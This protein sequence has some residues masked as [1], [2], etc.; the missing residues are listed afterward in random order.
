M[1]PNYFI[2]PVLELEATDQALNCSEE[3][4]VRK[5]SK[6]AMIYLPRFLPSSDNMHSTNPL[7]VFNME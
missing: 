2:T 4:M 5:M 7:V 6:F 3:T 1:E